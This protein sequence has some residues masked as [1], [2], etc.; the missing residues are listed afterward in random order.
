MP[1]SDTDR[2]RTV[3]V[4]LWKRLREYCGQSWVR[5]YGDVDGEAIKSWTDALSGYSEHQIARGVKWC[6]SWTRDFP[7]TLG[8]FREM[9]LT[10]RPEE[11]PNKTDERI[12]LEK[13]EGKPVAMLEQLARF[14]TSEIAKREIERM[15]R[16]LNGDDV[17]SFEL[18][19][20]NCGL[21]QRWPGAA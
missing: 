20:H 14:G 15:R 11:L 1:N 16:I 21:G 6:Q 19:Y 7:P 2:R 5:E 4:A 9:C 17:E 12:A 18:S 8:Q 10:V 3:I 13:R